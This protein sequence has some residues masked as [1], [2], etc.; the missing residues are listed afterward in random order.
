[1]SLFEQD[2]IQD[3]S[4]ARR[5]PRG[6]LVGIWALVVALL[7]LLGMSFLP[8]PYV[9]ERPG[10]V[11]DTLGEATG[12]DGEPVPLISISGAE[13][14]PTTGSLDLLTVS[15]VGS[16]EHRLS[17]VDVA[18]AWFDPTRSV[19]PMEKIFPP[20]QTSQDR[21]E[22]NAV[23]MDDSQDAATAAA[24]QN[25]GYPLD[26]QL[27]IA[28][29]LED[30]A[31]AD[32]FRAGDVVL[33]VDGAP[34][35]RA[36]AV[37]EA[38]GG[39]EGVQMVFDIERDARAQQVEITPRAAADETA[40]AWQIG[41]VVGTSY[42]FP[43]DVA[44]Q[45]DNVGG[46]SAGMMFALGIVDML[47]PGELTGGE[48]IAGTGTIS[49]GGEVGAIGGI[50]QKMWGAV[51]AGASFFLAPSTN[52]GEVVGNVP[53]GLQV[54]AVDTLDDAVAVL[55]EISSGGDLAALPTCSA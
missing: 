33:A 42:D 20:G 53:D 26:S 47:T 2:D 32:L 22:Q 24:L 9:I 31:A 29:V 4:A 35:D 30:S 52:C 18:L 48:R 46:P 8:S 50:R 41:V 21:E 7:A 40:A 28:H 43:F 55:D 12:A 54:F 5:M 15:V 51:D 34:L 36:E 25:L 44:I 16:P 38:V 6:V 23:L 19:V 1:M 3:A 11:Y 45:L 17:W 27:T 49:S 14:F 10:P 13:T 39:S 37:R